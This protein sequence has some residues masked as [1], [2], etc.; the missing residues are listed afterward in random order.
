MPSPE[1]SPSTSRTASAMNPQPRITSSTP[2]RRSHWSMYEM[3]GRPTSGTT[4]LGIVEVSGRRRVP[5][6]PARISACM[7]PRPLDDHHLPPD[8]FV[9]EPGCPDRLGIDEVAAVDD[10]APWHP[11]RHLRPVEL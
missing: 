2:C 7:S 11:L 9:D 8:A 10:Q 4:G 1:P 5:S 3:N 6:P